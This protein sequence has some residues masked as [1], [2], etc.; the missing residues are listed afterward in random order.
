MPC[1]N[2]FSFSDLIIPVFST[3]VVLVG[4]R[5]LYSN[6]KKLAS[7]NE[8]HTQAQKLD[9]VL[10]DIDLLCSG[11]WAGEVI[12]DEDK[13]RQANVRRNAARSYM[14]EYG[15]YTVSLM[16][17]MTTLNKHSKL[18]KLE[19][20]L[21]KLKQLATMDS[22]Y[23]EEIDMS[24]LASITMLINEVRSELWDNFRVIYPV[25]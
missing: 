1:S 9:D 19:F 22:E 10:K 8:T 6:A 2:S 24:R 23:R 3:F 16:Y 14:N 5:V 4:W 21:I 12:I 13:D 17:Y 25:S 15:H 20:D 11:F 7:R 18:T